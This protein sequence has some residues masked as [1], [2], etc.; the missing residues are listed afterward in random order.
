MKLVKCVPRTTKK[1]VPL[2][3]YGENIMECLNYRDGLEWLQ[4][5]QTYGLTNI[6][7]V[8]S[9]VPFNFKRSYFIPRKSSRQ[10]HLARILIDQVDF[11]QKGFLYVTN[12]GIAEIYDNDP[13]TDGYLKAIGQDKGLAES[14]YIIFSAGDEDKLSSLVTLAMY[15]DY[16]ALLVDKLDGRTTAFDISHDE[17]IDV[18]S[19]DAKVMQHIANV[20]ES[21]G[22]IQIE[23][24]DFED[25][26]VGGI[27]N[28]KKLS[29]MST[30]KLTALLNPR[31]HALIIPT[32]P[33]PKGWPKEILVK[34][35]RKNYVD[36]SQW[37]CDDWY[38]KLWHDT[39]QLLWWFGTDMYLKDSKM[40]PAFIYTRLENEYQQIYYP[41]LNIYVDI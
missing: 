38:I 5:N 11:N 18:M 32:E 15:Q 35:K 19:T 24:A 28:T 8:Y 10:I 3:Q 34:N 20:F 14:P 7:E 9:K 6:C 41:A 1:P 27:G 2:L 22:L 39:W 13:I 17:I 37:V 16:D 40:M 29:G 31:S 12:P 4:K 26:D 36:N 30:E 23:N 25:V 33:M 21:F